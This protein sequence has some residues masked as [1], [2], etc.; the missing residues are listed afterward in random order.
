MNIESLIRDIPDFPQKGIV[1][2]DISPLLADGPAFQQVINTLRDRHVGKG[3]DVVVGVEAR[4]FIFASAL[5]Y[6]LGAG[7]VLVRKPGKLPHDTHQQDYALEYGTNTLE[8]H[9]D[10]FRANQRVLIVDDVLATGGTIAATADLLANHF[11]VEIEEVNVLMEIDA[12]QGRA[13][14]HGLPVYSILHV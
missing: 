9:Q 3:I 10:A 8:I 5:A 12:L 13:K 1:F 4:G 11:H 14:L 2:K 6:A 7:T